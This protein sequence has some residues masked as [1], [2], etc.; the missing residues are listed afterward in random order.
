[1]T[2]KP[3]AIIV[4]G[5]IG[6]LTAGIALRQSGIDAV[7]YERAPELTEI[8]AGIAL[9]S[10]ALKVFSTLGLADQITACGAPLASGAIKTWNGKDII[11]EVASRF[12]TPDPLRAKPLMLNLPHASLPFPPHHPRLV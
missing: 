1:M 8:G 4:G 6:G 7:V 11:R 3:K 2:E 5:G 9:A 12:V 10:N